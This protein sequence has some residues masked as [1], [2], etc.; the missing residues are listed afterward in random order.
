MYQGE[1]QA[2]IRFT[3]NT[4]SR[5]VFPE[6]RCQSQFYKR[7]EECS[8]CKYILHITIVRRR[9]VGSIDGDQNEIENLGDEGLNRIP[10]TV[11]K[12]Y[13]KLLFQCVFVRLKDMHS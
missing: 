6:R 8:E 2:Y 12:K 4:G 10:D 13:V 1:V 7:P 9:E 11:F 5:F 3:V